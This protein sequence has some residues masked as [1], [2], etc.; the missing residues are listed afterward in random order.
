M[1][2]I[3]GTGSASS[4]NGNLPV[5]VLTH[6]RLGRKTFC[7]TSDVEQTY[8]HGATRTFVTLVTETCA[9]FI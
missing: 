3:T 1:G 5:M 2:T 8:A 6:G 4:S 9:Q 7:V